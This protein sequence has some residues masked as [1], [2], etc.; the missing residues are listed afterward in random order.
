MIVEFDIDTPVL[1]SALRNA[2]ETDVAIVQQHIGES[3]RLNAVLDI[4]GAFDAFEEGLGKD[5]SVADWLRFSTDRD[6][7]RYRVTLTERASELST[8]PCWSSDGVVFLDG[9][10]QRDEWRFCL[11]LP[12]EQSL[13]RY[14]RYCE[15]RDITLDPVRLSRGASTTTFERYGL[16]ST[17][18][19]T[20]VDASERG[21]FQ[22]PRDCTLEELA[23]A[24]NI[25][26]QALS[27]RL[28]RGTE[29]LI[30]ATLR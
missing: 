26:H 4:R 25:S 11:Q 5:D 15:A 16:T 27:E 9:R 23:A 21:F 7:R 29:S 1:Q 20:L 17:Q 14:V 6:R 8:Y 30:E 19:Q 10:R 12:N 3:E 18:A 22:I 13:Q 24:S 2:P 28:R